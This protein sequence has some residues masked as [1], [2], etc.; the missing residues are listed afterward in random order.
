MAVDKA[1]RLA[2]LKAKLNELKRLNP[3]HC[4]DTNTFVAHQLSQ[5]LYEQLEDL[6]EEIK[7]LEE[8]E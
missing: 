8:G 2:E 5:K 4:S 7:A 6:E 1:A 3:A